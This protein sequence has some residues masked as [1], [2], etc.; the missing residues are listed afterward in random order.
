MEQH[1]PYKPQHKVRIV[2][3]E[4]Q[5]DGHESAIIIIRR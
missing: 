3:A 5:F 4:R 1:P 2:T